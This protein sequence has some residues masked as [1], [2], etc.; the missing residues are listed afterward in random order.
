[1]KIK[2]YLNMVLWCS[3][4]NYEPLYKIL[5]ELNIVE[6]SE[7]KRKPIALRIIKYL[8]ENDLVKLYYTTWED[9]NIVE[10]KK[11]MYFDLLENDRNWEIPEE[12][13]DTYVAVGA[14]EKGLDYA[15]NS[16]L[17]DFIEW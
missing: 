11:E 12:E 3:T 1:M 15:C 10:I 17:P 8:I 9:I 13:G 4:E 2:K 16:K 5:W 6:I 14:T 7:D